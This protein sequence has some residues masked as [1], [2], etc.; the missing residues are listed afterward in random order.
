MDLPIKIV[1]GG[2]GV[3]GYEV[4]AKKKCLRRRIHAGSPHRGRGACPSENLR[5]N[6]RLH[7]VHKP[8][9]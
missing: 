3:R 5:S 7:P 8:R 9:L 2:L 1:I 4:Y 6:V